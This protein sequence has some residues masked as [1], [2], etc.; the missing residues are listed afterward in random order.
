MTSTSGVGALDSSVQQVL[1]QLQGN[2]TV[3]NSAATGYVAAY[4]S[5]PS[6]LT[7]STDASF[8]WGASGNTQVNHIMLQNNATINVLFDLDVATSAGSPICAPGQTMF[9]DV[10]TTTLHLQANGTPNL[11]GTSAGNI[12]VRAWL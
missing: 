2:L 7:A 6:A 8:T 11:N 3:V 1:T 9:F 4:G 10:K 5:N 12:V